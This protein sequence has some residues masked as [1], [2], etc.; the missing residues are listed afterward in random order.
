ML[1]RPG[2]EPATSRSADRRSPNRA[3]QAAVAVNFSGKIIS[4]P[5]SQLELDFKV[6]YPAR[7]FTLRAFPSQ[8]FYQKGMS[9]ARNVSFF[10][11]LPAKKNNRHLA[12]QE[13]KL[14]HFIQ[15][16][17]KNLTQ[18]KLSGILANTNSVELSSFQGIGFQTYLIVFTSLVMSNLLVFVSFF[19]M[20]KKK[21]MYLSLIPKALKPSF[22]YSQCPFHHHLH[23]LCG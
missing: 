18:R 14:S 15:V 5:Q 23:H 19:D 17:R 4:T 11:F 3:N 22:S 8:D 2:F 21:V 1:V 9:L 13:N 7:I 10:P 12:S 16:I 6:Q 20:L